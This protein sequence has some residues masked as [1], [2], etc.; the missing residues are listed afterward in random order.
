MSKRSRVEYIDNTIK[1]QRIPFKALHGAEGIKECF[2][3]EVEESLVDAISS[4]G[5]QTKGSW[6][7]NKILL[8]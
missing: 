8:L 3:R 7:K 4:L 2:L 6:M 5:K 1:N